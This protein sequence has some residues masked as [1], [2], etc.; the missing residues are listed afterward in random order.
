MIQ[1]K[2]LSKDEIGPVTLNAQGCRFGT[3]DIK[4]DA[5]E[6]PVLFVRTQDLQK[7]AAILVDESGSAFA[8][9]TQKYLDEMKRRFAAMGYDMSSIEACLVGGSN[10]ATWKIKKWKDV[11]KAFNLHPKEIDING[12]FYRKMSFNLKSG[13]VS[14]FREKHDQNAWNP[15]SASLSMNDGKHVFSKSQTGGIVANATCFFR[16]KRTFTAMRELI[17][18]EH[19]SMTPD[20]PFKIWCASCSNGAEAYS[21]TMY[22]HRLLIRTRAKCALAVFGTD[23]NAGMI[24]HAQA[25]EYDLSKA[26]IDKYRA[27]FEKYGTVDDT[28]V[29]FGRQIKQFVKFRTFDISKQPRKQTFRMIICA[30]VFQYYKDDARE[31]FLKNFVSVIQRPG[32]IFVGPVNPQITDRLGLEKLTKYGMLR[33]G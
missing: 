22:T 4:V 7:V 26:D 15:A 25:G 29:K 17:M 11:A 30:N 28:I 33:A 31:A 21:Y 1:Q 27:Y 8:H 3:T 2:L 5:G 9:T 23:I 19:L 10:N 6:S 24:E 32:Y 14:I 20:E 13:T 12:D 18:P 16:E